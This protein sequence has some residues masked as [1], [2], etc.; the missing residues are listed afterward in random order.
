M[1]FDY[2]PFAV[3]N[4]I[5]KVQDCRRSGDSDVVERSGYSRL[6]GL[7]DCFRRLPMACFFRDR[8]SHGVGLCD[9]QFYDGRSLEMSV[10]HGSTAA[11][12]QLFQTPDGTQAFRKPPAKGGALHPL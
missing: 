8:R 1:R 2:A 5:E 9:T 3:R 7:R 12:P 6:A 4:S 11:E 10:V